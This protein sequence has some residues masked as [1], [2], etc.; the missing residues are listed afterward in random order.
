MSW[1]VSLEKCFLS[2][3]CWSIFGWSIYVGALLTSLAIS[4]SGYPV[5]IIKFIKVS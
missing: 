1:E 5:L 2:D 3:F 4:P